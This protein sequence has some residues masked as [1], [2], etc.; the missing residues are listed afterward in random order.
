MHS[1][2]R[3]LVDLFTFRFRSRAS[4]ELEVIALRHQLKI[5]RFHHSK[6]IRVAGEDRILWIFLYRIWSGVARVMMVVKPKTVIRWHREGFRY[7]WRWK[8][9]SKPGPQIQV[10]IRDLAHKMRAENPLWGFRRIHAEIIKLGINVHSATIRRY[11]LVHDFVPRNPPGWKIFLRNHIHETVATDMFVVITKSYRLLY[12]VVFLELGRRRIAH[13]EVTYHPT[14][15][16]L[17]DQLTEAF[18]PKLFQKNCRPRYLLRDRD[19]SFGPKFRDRLKTLNISD[20]VISYK[21]PWQN[22]HVER[23]ILSI[24]RECLNHVIALN[25]RHVRVILKQYVKYYNQ[26]RPHWALDYDAPEHRSTHQRFMG[27]HIVA[28]PQ[29]GGL[30]HRYERRAA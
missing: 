17:A 9:R 22:I 20:R 15:E 23:L 30:H 3:A 24:R 4:L 28:I 18:E 7:Y 5:M 27:K 6:N 14:Q 19:S 1:I 2:L 12:V 8:C 29:V 11:L 13:F 16:W 21:S 25:D 10:D 26:S